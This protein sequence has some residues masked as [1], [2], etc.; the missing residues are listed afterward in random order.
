[1]FSTVSKTNA[2]ILDLILRLQL[3]SIWTS[4]KNLFDKELQGIFE[5]TV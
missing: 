2:I 5:D 4:L 3:Y 1:M